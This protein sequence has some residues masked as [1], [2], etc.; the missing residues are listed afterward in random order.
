MANAEFM[1][2]GVWHFVFI[3]LFQG[4]IQCVCVCVCALQSL[5]GLIL[6]VKVDP[7]VVLCTLSPECFCAL[8][9]ALRPGF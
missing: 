5:R 3:Q 4:G 8:S 6:I 2:G 9:R 1:S 7:L